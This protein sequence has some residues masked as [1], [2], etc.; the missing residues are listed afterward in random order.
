M[1]DESP[2]RAGVGA[3]SPLEQGQAT[4]VPPAAESAGFGAK[5]KRLGSES[6]IYGLSSI[7]GRFLNYLLVP[8]YAHEFTAS[9]NGVQAK[10][11][12]YIP[13]IYLVFYLG[14]DVAYMRN[15]AAKDGTHEDRQRAFSMSFGA[16]LMVGGA[17]AALGALFAPEVGRLFRMEPTVFRYML[18]IVFS[19]ALLAVPYAHLRM[20]NRAWRYALLRLLFVAVNLSLN[21]WLIAGLHWGVTAI[22]FSNLVANLLVLVLLVPELVRL[23]R[24][25]LVRGGPWKALWKYALP[26]M[27]AM[28]AVSVVENGDLAVLNYLPDRVAQAL[29]QLDSAEAV[30][31]VFNFNY[32]LGV[33]M[34]LV[35]QMFRMAWTPFSLQHAEE[36]GAPELYSRV[37]TALML[38]C[39]VVFL[40]VSLLLPVVVHIPWV[41]HI[42]KEPSYWQGLPIV[43]VILLAYM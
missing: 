4:A 16:I 24:P 30:L 1:E 20:R 6:L 14:M 38:V 13:M 19:D 29:Y 28:L 21:I 3:D 39:S 22:F 43:P 15:T 27:P 41:Y 31:G 18:A 36:P 9:L 25:A 34:L 10:V 42:V 26:I 2:P 11:Y 5:L 35:V 8:F 40:G 33:A 37:L 7:V 17:I 23:F 12:T 32:K